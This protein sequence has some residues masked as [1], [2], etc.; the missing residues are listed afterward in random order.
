MSL[1]GGRLPNFLR[2]QLA[3]S[4]VHFDI[5]EIDRLGYTLE[6]LAIDDHVDVPLREAS[7]LKSIVKLLLL[8]DEGAFYI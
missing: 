2:N 6:V 7:L 4:C 3:K 8:V 1:R 5:G